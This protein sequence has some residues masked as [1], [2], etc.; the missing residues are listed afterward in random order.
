[1]KR[2]L[3]LAL[4]AGLPLS[5]PAHTFKTDRSSVVKAYLYETETQILSSYLADGSHIRYREVPEKIYQD[6]KKAPLKGGYYKAFIR[7]AF[8]SEVVRKKKP[9]PPPA[10]KK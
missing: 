3:I 1:M 9:A 10:E 2:F 8:P 5:I 7:N 4:I 6:L